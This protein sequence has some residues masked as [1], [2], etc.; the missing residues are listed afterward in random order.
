MCD[1]I[2]RTASCG[3]KFRVHLRERDWPSLVRG[4]ASHCRGQYGGTLIAQEKEVGQDFLELGLIETKAKFIVRTAYKA[5]PVPLPSLYSV[6]STCTPSV[7]LLYS[8]R[9]VRTQRP[10]QSA[11]YFPSLLVHVHHSSMVAPAFVLLADCVAWSLGLLDRRGQCW[12]GMRNEEQLYLIHGAIMG[13]IFSGVSA[14]CAALVQEFASSA[15]IHSASRSALVLMP[16]CSNA[17]HISLMDGEL[18]YRN[19]ALMQFV[20]FPVCPFF[21]DPRTG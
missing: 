6:K 14:L 7:A 21:P 19:R 1:S 2:S 5:S 4:C 3:T 9:K 10:S 18:D 11:R 13:A 20:R 8:I 16:F 12:W 15:L 17:A